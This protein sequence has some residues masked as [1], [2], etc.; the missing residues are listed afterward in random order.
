MLASLN[1]S[2]GVG[3]DI[4]PKMVDRARDAHPEAHLEFRVGDMHTVE[5]DET[6]DVIILDHLVGYLR[7]IHSCFAKLRAA[8]HPRTRIY[9]LSLNHVW[10]PMLGVGKLLGMVTKQPGDTNWVSRGD[11]INIL[12][13]DG[14]EHVS[15][16][17]AAALP[18]SC[19]AG[20]PFI[21]PVFV[22]VAGAADAG[23]VGL[24]GGSAVGGA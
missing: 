5:I 6:F 8:C 18:V 2:R 17:T 12:E 13:L 19:A 15:C 23:D 3:I 9:I 20:E 14:Y 24:C 11:L 4:S 16:T 10:K 7:D 22:S 1:P 21:E